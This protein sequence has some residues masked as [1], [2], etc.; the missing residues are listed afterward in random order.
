MMFNTVQLFN[1]NE[2]Q[3]NWGKI[4]QSVES[5]SITGLIC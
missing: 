1:L 2:N 3:K 5:G 4:P